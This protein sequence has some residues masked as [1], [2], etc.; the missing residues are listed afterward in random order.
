LSPTSLDQCLLYKRDQSQ[1]Q[2]LVS[3][4][5]DDSLAVGDAA[6]FV[7]EDEKVTRFQHK[8]AKTLR[9]DS[10]IVVNGATIHQDDCGLKLVQEEHVNKLTFDAEEKSP[11][12]FA[13]IS[14]LTAT[15]TT[16][17]STAS[18][19][20][21]FVALDVSG[22]LRLVVF[23]DAEF[24][25][26][27]DH[28]SQTGYFIALVDQTNKANVIAYRS[29]KCRRV[30][31]SSFASELLA[32]MEA[33]DMGV[34]LKEQLFEILVEHVA[35]WCIVDSRTVYNAVVR[36][37]AVTEK[38]LAVDIAVLREAHLFREM[39][40][41]FW[42]PSDQTGAD[43]MTKFDVSN[44]VFEALVFKNCLLNPGAWV[45]RRSQSGKA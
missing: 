16:V 23:S 29:K 25:T 34:A 22:P 28:T 35:L 21:P 14:R 1:R 7:L 33:F 8:P 30:T 17:K 31:R 32:L 20:L 42:V 37:G 19:G 43:A 5:V 18:V 41:L 13:S 2:A 40:Q 9:R 24:N 4:Q 15:C 45:E 44:K 36:M 11:A 3:V 6:Y 27:A 26:N 10:P 38:R 12:T 39:E